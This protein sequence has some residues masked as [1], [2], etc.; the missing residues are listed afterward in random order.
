MNEYVTCVVC[1]RRFIGKI[2][3]GGDGSALVPRKHYQ[4]I[5]ITNNLGITLL[6]NTKIV[7]NGSYRIADDEPPKEEG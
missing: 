1:K 2:P 7:C 3:K 4:Y 5:P 6:P